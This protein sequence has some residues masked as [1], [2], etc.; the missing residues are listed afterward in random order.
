[1]ILE[2]LK[3]TLIE[4]SSKSTAIQIW[5]LKENIQAEVLNYIYSNKSYSD[6]IFYWWTSMRFLLWLN[7]LSEDLDFVKSWEFEYQKLA[8]DLSEYFDWIWL[9]IDTKVQ[10]FR[11]TLKFRNLLQNFWIK[12]QNSD[13]LYLKIEISDHFSFCKNFKTQIYPIDYKDKSIFIKSLESWTL[14]ATKLNAVL[15]RKREKQTPNWILYVKWRD[16]YD[17][18]RYL[19]K[20][21]KPN[22]DCI[23][24]IETIQDLKDKLINVVNSVDF[25]LVYS[26]L[27]WFLENKSALEFIKT[28]WKSYI[29]EQIEKW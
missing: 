10:K 1:M 5:Y 16:F 7:R 29:I 13:D 28:N 27:I 8:N 2:T 6:L 19:Q 22:I 15:Y 18:F 24:D 20:W 26:D 9:K 17:L 3:A 14:F 4:H 23:Q 21:I 25:N 11:I 12:Y